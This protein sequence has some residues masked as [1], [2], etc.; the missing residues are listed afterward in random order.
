MKKVTLYQAKTDEVFFRNMRARHT[1]DYAPL[2]DM[3]PVVMLRM[4]KEV[5]D[6]LDDVFYMMN[7]EEYRYSLNYSMS[8]GDIVDIDGKLYRCLPIGWETVQK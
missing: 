7:C 4:N 2:S 5:S 8:V 6:I 1:N 3:E